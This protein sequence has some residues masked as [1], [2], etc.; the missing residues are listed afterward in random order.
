MVARTSHNVICYAYIVCLVNHN[1][2]WNH[3]LHLGPQLTKHC[4]YCISL[5]S[6]WCF[7]K[8]SH[9]ELSLNS[10]LSKLCKILLSSITDHSSQLRITLS[11]QLPDRFRTL[12]GTE[13]PPPVPTLRLK[14]S[15]NFLKYN[16]YHITVITVHNFNDAISPYVL[17]LTK[18]CKHSLSLPRVLHVQ[19]SWS[20]LL[21]LPQ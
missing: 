11:A 15:I 4:A 21:W 8:Q 12:Y 9:F 10:G 1:D 19:S 5:P 17:R 2:V 16:A 3:L 18:L 20:T 13:R 6:F 14:S 7:I